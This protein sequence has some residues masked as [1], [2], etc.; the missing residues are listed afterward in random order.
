MKLRIAT[1]LLIMVWMYVVASAHPTQISRLDNAI[2]QREYFQQNKENRVD[3]IRRLLTS[4]A[5][6]ETRFCLHHPLFLE[7][8]A[9][10]F[11]STML[12]V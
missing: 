5:D 6:K 8:L 11:D 10:T 7:Y 2:S 4:D 1:S 9:S 3:S 12:Y